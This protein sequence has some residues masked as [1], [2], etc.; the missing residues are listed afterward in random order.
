LPAAYAKLTA[1]GLTWIT[2]GAVQDHF[3]TDARTAAVS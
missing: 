2:A 1:F 3:V